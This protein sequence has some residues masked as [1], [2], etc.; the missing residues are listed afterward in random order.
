MRDASHMRTTLNLDDDILQSA[1][2]LAERYE[3]T[4]G[5]VLSELARESL[6]KRR[7]AKGVNRNGIPIFKNVPEAPSLNIDSTNALRDS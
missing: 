7:A 6:A 2:A 3:K 1:R 5:E 4:L